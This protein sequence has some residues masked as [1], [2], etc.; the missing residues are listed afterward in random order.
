MT[1]G[2]RLPYRDDT[3]DGEQSAA[4]DLV[5]LAA[6]DQAAAADEAWGTA[7]R[8]FLLAPH[9]ERESRLRVLQEAAREALKAG[10]AVDAARRG[11]RR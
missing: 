6:A 2:A 11:G 8:R 9:G 7:Q 10:L 1:P 5:V 4:D 3:F